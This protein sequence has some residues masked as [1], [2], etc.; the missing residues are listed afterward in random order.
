MKTMTLS[1]FQNWWSLSTWFNTSSDR[2]TCMEAHWTWSPHSPILHSVGSSSTLLGW[3]PT[4]AW[5]LP[6]WQCTI[7]LIQL[8][9]AKSGAGRRSI[10]QLSEKRSGRVLWLIQH[11]LSCSRSTMVVCIALPIVSPRSTRHVP[12]SD[13][14]RL[15]SMLTA[16]LSN[17]TVSD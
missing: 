10:Y 7:E 1:D 8:A 14:Y 2:L 9:F 5:W 16:E 4:T 13:R 6:S 12:R 11:H 15:G 3:F 17:E